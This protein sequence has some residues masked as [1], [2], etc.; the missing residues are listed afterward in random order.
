MIQ[1]NYLFKLIGCPYKGRLPYSEADRL[2][3]F[4]REDEQ[5]SITDRLI[6]WRLTILYGASG[7]GKSSVLRAGVA[8]QLRQIARQNLEKYEKPELAVV[9]V[10]LLEGKLA[11]EKSSLEPLTELK[12]AIAREIT[13][14][15]LLK[16]QAVQ[17]ISP[18]LSFVKTLQK[19]TE[20]VQK[21]KGGGRLFI[22]LDQFEDC[23][24]YLLDKQRQDEQGKETFEDALSAAINDT[25]LNVNFLLAIREESLAKLDYFKGRIRNLLDNRLEIKRLD[26]NS[27]L[28]A[29][30]KPLDEYNRHKIILDKLL[31]SRL[32]ILYGD[33]DAHKSTV[34]RDAIYHYLSQDPKFTVVLLTDWNT[35]KDPQLNL[36]QK[37]RA[38]LETRG[39]EQSSVEELSFAEVFKKCAKTIDSKEEESKLVI[40]LDQFEKYFSTQPNK[41]QKQVF[42]QELL[43]VLEEIT[44]V[45]FL[46]SISTDEIAQFK[47]SKKRDISRWLKHYLHLYQDQIEV[48]SLEEQFTPK[49]LHHQVLSER[50]ISFE[51]A[52][53]DQKQLQYEILE[54]I[55]EQSQELTDSRIETPLLQIVMQSLWEKEREDGSLCLRRETFFSKLGGVEGIVDKDWIELIPKFS[56]I[57]GLEGIRHIEDIIALLFHYLVTSTGR[58]ITYSIQELVD[59]LNND[60]YLYNFP[61]LDEDKIKILLK[62]L[63]QSEFRILRPLPNQRYEILYSVLGKAI[64]KWQKQRKERIEREKAEEKAEEKAQKE[65]ILAEAQQSIIN[66]L[67]SLSRSEQEN[68]KAALLA[69]Q[70]YLLDQ[71]FNVDMLNEVDKVL[72]KAVNNAYFSHILSSHD[73]QVSSV[74][75]R[76]GSNTVALGSFDGTVELLKL[77]T[78]TKTIPDKIKLS[79]DLNTRENQQ[80]VRGILSIAISQ[81]GEKLAAGCGDKKVRV[82]DLNLPDIKVL[83]LSGHENE[84]WSVAFSPDGKLLASGGWDNKVYLWDLEN[85]KKTPICGRN[86]P[87]WVWSVAFSPDGRTLAA[88]CRNGT[89]WLWELLPSEKLKLPRI[90][91]NPK[92]L[93]VH[94]EKNWRKL[95]KHDTNQLRENGE[96]FSV[97]FSADGLLAAGSRDGQIRLWKLNQPYDADPIWRGDT[98]IAPRSLIF[99]EDGQ[100]LASGNDDVKHWGESGTVT[101][102]KRVN[103]DP[104]NFHKQASLKE[105]PMGVTPSMGVT[106]VA[107]ILDNQWLVSG[108]WDGTVRLWDLEPP[109][110]E[111]IP[112]E[113]HQEAVMTVAFSPTGNLFASGSYD[114]ATG[115]WELNNRDRRLISRTDHEKGNVNSVAFSPDGTILASGTQE[116]EV[117]LWNI[118]ESDIIKPLAN[119]DDKQEISSVAF[120]PAEDKKILAAGSYSCKV[121]LW[122]ISNINQPK[123]LPPLEGH[124]DRVNTVAFSPDGKILA[125]GDNNHIVRLWRNPKIPDAPSIKLTRFEG[126]ISSIAFSS[127]PFNELYMLA[128]ATNRETIELWDISPLQKHPNAEPIFLRDYSSLKELKGT[129]VAFSLDGL[130][131]ASGN[132]DGKVRLWDLQQPK[133]SPIVLEGH[134]GAVKTLAFSPDG[135]WLAAG[136]ED[137]TI[138][139]W[140]TKTEKIA[141]MVCQKVWRN[142]T[143]EEWK[144]FVGEHIPYECTCPKLPSG[145]GLGASGQSD[146]SRTEFKPQLREDKLMS[147]QRE[148]FDKLRAYATD[149]EQDLSEKE[150]AKAFNKTK[151]D[152][153]ESMT[154]DALCRSGFIIKTYDEQKNIKYSLSL[155]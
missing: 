36:Q 84:V 106:S 18:D 52:L 76:A 109:V 57:E 149:R 96:I 64:Y 33:S 102:W 151:L 15:F 155:G 131:L 89:V 154:L 132:N 54:K 105:P 23:L 9:V 101:L 30:T 45:N 85:Y 53:P 108:S 129:C 6:S 1:D 137:G 20:V 10:S 128:V 95:R 139:I 107:F 104:I 78:K 148:L 28:K 49:D 152:E 58:Q 146:T 77:K 153:V 48:E 103:V 69:R 143:G 81:D 24:D 138:R 63:S 135:E 35:S 8:Y 74:A 50:L 86:H 17:P 71:K 43:N 126:K 116:G 11:D 140:M 91:Q 38:E 72:R 121:L 141:N 145:Q 32:T 122:D 94:Q 68:E 14:L 4:G 127:Q 112:L 147:K 119:E 123:S 124:R 97:A 125:S 21:E 16:E 5:E 65:Q 70:A 82:W 37:I 80:D 92:I 44:N 31:N 142:L 133:A 40:I 115:L 87:D 46:I 39:I 47:L 61:K 22:I 83:E 93:S 51:E 3:F 79:C 144:E 7:V 60:C 136:S 117:C 90:L 41:A 111:L 130:F 56:M 118:H 113:E 150:I 19:W 25:S 75:F 99:S 73:K 100:W 26:E 27:A 88:G 114:N 62:K 34:L 12:E 120:Y 2:F 110:T 13:D 66:K 98:S 55:K 29:I 134:K 67:V 59:Y 42:I